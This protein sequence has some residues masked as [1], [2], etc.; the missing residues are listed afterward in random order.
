MTTTALRDFMLEQGASQKNVFMEWDKIYALNKQILDPSVPRYTAVDMD[1]AVK[2]TITN[3][4][5]KPE[6]PIDAF[7]LSLTRRS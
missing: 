5:E 6:L 4:P 3:G 1:G 7:L 2:L